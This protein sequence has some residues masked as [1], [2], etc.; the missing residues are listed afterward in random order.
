MRFLVKVTLNTETTND[1]VRAGEMGATIHQILGDMETEAVYFGEEVGERTA[2]I[3]V[4]LDDASQIPEIAEPWFLAFDAQVEFHPVMTP[5][6]LSRASGSIEEA[7]K[8][9]G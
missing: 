2:Y 5:E 9:F 3:F 7:A 1:L 6:D 4:D 8:N